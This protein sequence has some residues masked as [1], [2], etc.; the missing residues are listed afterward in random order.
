MTKKDWEK[1]KFII[2]TKKIDIKDY[3]FPPNGMSPEC[4]KVVFILDQAIKT[5]KKGSDLSEE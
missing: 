3:T 4:M 2:N 1:E 5:I